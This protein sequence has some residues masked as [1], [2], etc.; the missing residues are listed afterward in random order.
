MDDEEYVTKKLNQVFFKK[1]QIYGGERVKEKPEPFLS[2]P[3]PPSRSKSVRERRRR[4]SLAV[5][6]EESDDQITKPRRRNSSIQDE[7]AIH[8]AYHALLNEYKRV[9]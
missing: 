3:N 9:S 5:T 2:S 4:S 8:D 7:R 1:I 6:D